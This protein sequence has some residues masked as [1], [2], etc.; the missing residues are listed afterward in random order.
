MLIVASPVI[1]LI[2]TCCLGEITTSTG[3]ST[4]SIRSDKSTGR[5]TTI[6]DIEVE[7]AI[8]T[9]RIKQ[10]LIDSNI[11]VDSLIEQLRTMS[12]VK[13]KKVPLLDEDVFMKI[14]SIDEFWKS[15][16]RYWN[17]YDYDLLRF[18]IRITECEEANSVLQKFLSRIDP[19]MIED[20]NLV[21]HCGEYQEEG[22][23]KPTLRIKV[24]AEKCTFDVQRKAKEMVSR[25]YN[26]EKYV[27]RFKGIKQGCIEL[28]YH[29]STAVMAY[30]LQC[31]ITRT[32]LAEL[33]VCKI[34]SIY[35]ND[36]DILV[37][38]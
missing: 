5:L 12:A 38:T 28:L 22:S 20:A 14:Q 18:I 16:S 25:I 24:N 10:V 29:A 30:L 15:L 19:T 11:N 8:M 31:K 4:T 1:R 7:F 23:L 32:I 17:L 36:F 34:I 37:S 21:L 26:L 2:I 6:E 27:L 33:S 13:I 35:I 9:K 3:E